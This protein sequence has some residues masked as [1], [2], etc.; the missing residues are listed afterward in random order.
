[1]QNVLRAPVDR[2][3]WS[4][5]FSFSSGCLKQPSERGGKHRNL[6]TAVLNNI[7]AFSAGQQKQEHFPLSSKRA[8]TKSDVEAIE[9][10]IVRRAVAKL[11]EGAVKGAIRH[12]CSSDT[13]QKPT[14]TTYCHL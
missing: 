10:A 1:M 7:K 3:A 12:L 2:Q 5:L 4:R 9:A 8:A 13:L 14:F 6:T 11:D